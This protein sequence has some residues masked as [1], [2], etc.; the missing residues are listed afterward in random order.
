M[1]A[2]LVEIGG[3]VRA[4]VRGVAVDGTSSTALLV[5]ASSGR[6]LGRPRMYD[7]AQPGPAVDSVRVCSLPSPTGR[8][9]GQVRVPA[10][11]VVSPESTTS[12]RTRCW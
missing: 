5:D 12:A 6:P 10:H 9:I 3:E 8:K 11:A 7:E 2:N 1:M 4:A